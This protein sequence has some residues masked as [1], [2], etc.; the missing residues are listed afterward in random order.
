MIDN[1][2]IMK[3]KPQTEKKYLQKSYHI[4]DCYQKYTKNT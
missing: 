2:K 4:K 3:R 1:V